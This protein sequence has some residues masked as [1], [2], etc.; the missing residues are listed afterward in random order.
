M[1]KALKPERVLLARD[2]PKTGS[3]K[4]MRRVVCA[5]YLGKEPSAVSW[6]R[7]RRGGEA[8]SEAT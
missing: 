4:I 1:G 6:S 5:A 3:T 8:I 2:I 7:E